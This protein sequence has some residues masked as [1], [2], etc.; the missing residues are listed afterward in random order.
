MRSGTP[1][2]ALARRWTLGAGAVLVAIGWIV[3][4]GG[5]AAS[6]AV[7]A[8]IVVLFL[9]T[10]AVALRLLG[11][12]DVP[13]GMGL[14]VFLLAFA[15]RLLVVLFAV[16][17]IIRFD[18]VDAQWLGVSIVVCALVWITTHTWHAW[19]RSRSELTVEPTNA[20]EQGAQEGVGRNDADR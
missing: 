11:R 1:A 5:A 3:T 13:G 7:G 14:V 10:G 20:A 15:L 17:L 16:A 19:R 18:W 6:S 2:H 8:L 4:S 9:S 12:E